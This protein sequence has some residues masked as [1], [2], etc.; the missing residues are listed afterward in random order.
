MLIGIT[1]IDALTAYQELMRSL[2]RFIDD[3][4]AFLS[5]SSRANSSTHT[6]KPSV[7]NSHKQLNKFGSFLLIAV[8]KV[9]HLT[10]YQGVNTK[11]HL[12]RDSHS[13]AS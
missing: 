9:L 2:D 13:S 8:V 12:H 5:E 11:N 10:C 4:K 7:I 6:Q 1:A 3:S